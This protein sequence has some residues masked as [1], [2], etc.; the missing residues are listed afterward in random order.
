MDDKSASKPTSASASS[1]PSA[2]T[3]PT[4][5]EAPS[6]YPESE[7]QVGR[8]TH[9]LITQGVRIDVPNELPPSGSG[10]NYAD[11][12]FGPGTP[13]RTPDEIAARGKATWSR[14]IADDWD[15]AAGP[16]AAPDEAEQG[17]D[18]A[19][20]PPADGQAAVGQQQTVQDAKTNADKGGQ[21]PP[22]QKGQ[23]K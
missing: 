15:S 9:Q 19:V 7:D 2:S 1:D 13:D 10:M 4:E 17:A 8:T 3:D 20:K 12:S 16:G 21:T 11:D 6:D 22:P 5:N 23:P 14:V 18:Q